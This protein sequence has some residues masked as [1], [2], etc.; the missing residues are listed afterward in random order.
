MRCI[1]GIV[2]RVNLQ[3]ALRVLATGMLIVPAAP[4]NAQSLTLL[5]PNSAWANVV[6]GEAL[7]VDVREQV[8][9]PGIAVG[10][11]H[12]PSTTISSIAGRIDPG[13][14]VIVYGDGP[15][16]PN[17][18]QVLRGMHTGEIA[19]LAGGSD[20]WDAASLPVSRMKQSRG[21]YRLH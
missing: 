11:I 3:P 16:P 15:V 19:V 6:R 21:M 8:T 9:D 1:L 2:R 14:L 17:A 18:L 4:T 12:A 10:A 13:M 20:A 5:E 7:L